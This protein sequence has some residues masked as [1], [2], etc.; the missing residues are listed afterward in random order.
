MRAGSAAGPRNG[1]S[2]PGTSPR[3]SRS[4]GSSLRRDCGL[5]QTIAT[6]A[7]LTAV[8]PAVVIFTVDPP[9]ADLG[10]AAVFADLA[11]EATVVWVVPEGLEGLVSPAFG[12][13]GG[14]EVLGE[15][16]SVAD[17]ILDAMHGGV[18]AS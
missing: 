15:H 17:E 8:P 10:A 5:V 13:A 6:A 16:Q 4:S 9:I 14:A 3:C 7:G 11:A 18:T 2:R 12:T 1:W